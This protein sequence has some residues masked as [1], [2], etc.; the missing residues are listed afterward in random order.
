MKGGEDIHTNENENEEEKERME[1]EIERECLPGK[2]NNNNEPRGRKG[3]GPERKKEKTAKLERKKE[4]KEGGK[5]YM[6]THFLDG[7]AF[8][9]PMLLLFSAFFPC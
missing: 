5:T 2:Q 1:R 7:P 3:R 9:F 4:T 8:F 6:H